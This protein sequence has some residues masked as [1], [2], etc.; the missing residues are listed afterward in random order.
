MPT[1]TS[2]RFSR[3]ERR[4]HSRIHLKTEQELAVRALLYGKDVL[5]VLPTGCGK[6]LIYQMFVRAAKDFQMNDKAT[7]ACYFSF[8]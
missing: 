4:R 3:F 6:S 5:A 2:Y 1:R 8:G 7:I